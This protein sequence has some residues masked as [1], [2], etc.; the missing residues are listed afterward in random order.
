M[1]VYNF[2]S[3]QTINCSI[4]TVFSFFSSPENLKVLTP[5]RLGFK[6]L[7]PSPINMSKGCIIDYLIYL[8]GI[9]V[10][11]R[12]IITDYDP[13]YMFIDQQI[14]GPYT[15]WHHK[16]S[17]REIK[18]G[19]EIRDRVVYSIPVGWMGRLLHKFWIKKDLENI[20]SYRKNIIAGLFVDDNYK[21]YLKNT[22]M[23]I[24]T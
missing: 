12:S 11:W 1:K 22:V 23:D 3:K 16:H 5:P 6:I 18:N 17:F 2:E 4:E 14:K 13:P 19:V 20:F 10:H 15:L 9:P 24:S 8:M 21:M 7:T